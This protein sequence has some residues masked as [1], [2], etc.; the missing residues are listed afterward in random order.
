MPS[1][2]RSRIHGRSRS[3]RD[4]CGDRPWSHAPSRAAGRRWRN[5]PPCCP[6]NHNHVAAT[7]RLAGAVLLASI[8]SRPSTIASS[9][10][11]P[12]RACCPVH[13]QHDSF[14]LL[15]EFIQRNV[16]AEFDRVLI[17][18]PRLSIIFVSSRAISTGSRSAMMPYV[19]RPPGMIRFSKIVTRVAQHCQFAG[20]GKPRWPGADHGYGSA[21]RRGFHYRIAAC[22]RA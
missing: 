21:R 8:Y 16:P 17:W 22:S 13:T 14:E 10:R 7:R 11:L 18:T 12:G 6:H 1:L 3:S 15:L 9:P 4:P 2:R 5:R 19:E 20:A